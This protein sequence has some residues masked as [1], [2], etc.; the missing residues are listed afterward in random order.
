MDA[1][2]HIR[3]SMGQVAQWRE[4]QAAN[5]ALA[6]AVASVKRFQAQRFVG[7]YTDLMREPAIRPA[8]Q[9]FLDELYSAADFSSRDAQF[10][11]IAGT[12]QS[13]F[14]RPVIGTALTL[15]QLHAQTE[16]LDHAMGVAWISQDLAQAAPPDIHSTAQDTAPYA[17]L[18]A[19]AWKQVGQPDARRS[20]LG[21]VM[22]LGRDLTRLTRTPGLHT[23]LRL[24]QRP[25]RAAGL[26]ALQHFLEAGFTT[27]GAMARQ[28]SAAERFLNT[29]QERETQLMALLFEAP[30]VACETEL[31]RL[32]GQAS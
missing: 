7:T 21:K 23:M 24:M 31:Q 26:D 15:A 8:T 9:F 12:L 19:A 22:E 13:I 2:D 30:L 27:F 25:A 29:V 32:L 1:A 4:A 16:T 5:P 14:P 3:Q 20:Q 17:A 28:R 6:A 18:Y 10:T 11:R